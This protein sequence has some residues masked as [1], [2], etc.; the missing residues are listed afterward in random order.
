MPN[1]RISDLVKK[2]TLVSNGFDQNFDDQA[3]LLLAREKSHN[4]TINY[5]NF[6][7]SITDHSV[8]V[9]GHQN[10]SGEKTYF[11]DAHFLK[12]VSIDGDLTVKGDVFNLKFETGISP[13]D[14]QDW[15][16][17]A[18][19]AG[20]EVKYQHE[21]W[22]AAFDALDSDEPNV[23]GTKATGSIEVLDFSKIINGDM[24]RLTDTN[25]VTHGFIEGDDWTIGA[26]NEITAT[27]IATT[28]NEHPEFSASSPSNSAIVHISQDKVGVAGNTTIVYDTANQM[29]LSAVDFSG[30][31][32]SATNPWEIVTKKHV[33]DFLTNLESDLA[34]EGVVKVNAQ[35]SLASLTIEKHPK[36]SLVIHSTGDV[37][38]EGRLEATELVIP[39]VGDLHEGS[40]VLRPDHSYSEGEKGTVI[41]DD[42]FIFICT[43]DSDGTDANKV[44]WKRFAISEW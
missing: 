14:L 21:A 41:F 7:E 8:Q 18:Y 38:M 19:S 16:A 6:K 15:Q 17:S 3:L 33:D 20:A 10:V 36:E 13:E 28:I 27:N 44:A 32:G 37:R 30:G 12:N 26:D 2:E 42:D 9:T 43:I 40:A 39:K 4:E 35:N 31:L 24:V 1:S 11:D 5:R 23:P 29:Q 22:R 25:G 34:V